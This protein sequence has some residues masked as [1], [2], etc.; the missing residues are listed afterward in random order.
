M[1]SAT[2][3]R[4]THLPLPP[5]PRS[6]SLSLPLSLCGLSV[7]WKIRDCSFLQL[8]LEDF[9]CQRIGEFHIKEIALLLYSQS[10]HC[11]AL[12]CWAE[13]HRLC[14]ETDKQM[15]KIKMSNIVMS[16]A[17][18]CS[19]TYYAAHVEKP[20][21]DLSVTAKTTWFRQMAVVC[22]AH[23]PPCMFKEL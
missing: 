13:A 4:I 14:V 5:L 12:K 7:T 16:N 2:S 8:R 23:P 10:C 20:E 3:V 9:S 22:Q 15:E 6:L 18:I 1:H 19:Q 11:G 21:Q 17:Y